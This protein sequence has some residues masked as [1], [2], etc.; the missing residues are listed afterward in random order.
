MRAAGLSRAELADLNEWRVALLQMLLPWVGASLALS[1]LL[2]VALSG[3]SAA[4]PYWYLAV[5]GICLM[6]AARH[7]RQ[8]PR[9]LSFVFALSLLCVVAERALV[10]GWAPGVVAVVVSLEIFV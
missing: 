2:F 8:A 10:L 1:P 4:A 9:A 3:L 5:V 7:A 6:L